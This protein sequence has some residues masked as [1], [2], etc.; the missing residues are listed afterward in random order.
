MASKFEEY[1][2][3]LRKEKAAAIAAK[4]KAQ[5]E[6]QRQK[7]EK[8]DTHLENLKER[9]RVADL[10]LARS[11]R[12]KDEQAA[13]GAAG[14]DPAAPRSHAHL[15]LSDCSKH[16]VD[17]V[18]A[19]PLSKRDRQHLS[20]LLQTV[21]IMANS[22]ITEAHSAS[23]PVPHEQIVD[24]ILDNSYHACKNLD[25]FL[26]E[27]QQKHDPYSAIRCNCKRMHFIHASTL[28]KS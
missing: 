17:V 25:F 15:G 24:S 1:D 13:A 21:K 6:H 27:M 26:Q 20:G 19:Y 8:Q 23:V 10:E 3:R 18:S 5:A 22:A 12:L 2:A 16:S 14:P 28:N 4:K 11:Q 9:A 7:K